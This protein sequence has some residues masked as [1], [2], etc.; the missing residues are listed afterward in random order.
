MSLS[1]CCTPPSSQLYILMIITLFADQAQVKNAKI[2]YSYPTAQAE[3][4]SLT[5]WVIRD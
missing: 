4:G 5:E 3:A 1:L 2:L